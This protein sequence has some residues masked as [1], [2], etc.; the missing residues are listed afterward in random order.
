ML[1]LRELGRRPNPRLQLTIASASRAAVMDEDWPAAV[2][3]LSLE[4]DIARR[5]DDAVLHVETLLLRAKVRSR[6]NDRL[7][8]NEDLDAAMRMIAT[9]KDPALRSIEGADAKAIQARY[10]RMPWNRSHC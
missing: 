10:Q 8:A 7:A 4:I 6:I 2:A 9:L 5:V 1:A 3:F